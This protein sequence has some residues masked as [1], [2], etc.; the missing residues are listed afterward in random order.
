MDKQTRWIT[1]RSKLMSMKIEENEETGKRKCSIREMK[2][3]TG[4]EGEA[5]EKYE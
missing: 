2:M 3:K 5:E 1:R 4:R